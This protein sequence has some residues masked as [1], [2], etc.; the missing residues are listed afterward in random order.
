MSHHA[1]SHHDRVKGFFQT[2][3]EDEQFIIFCIDDYHNI[4]IKHRPE[5][6]TQTQSVHTST[7]LVKIF[8]NIKAVP[9]NPHQPLLPVNPVDKKLCKKLT[10][11]NMATFPK[12]MLATC[13]IGW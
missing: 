9:N 13:Q 11:K 1:A 10:D 12:H 8:P 2:A 4:Q 3:I 5:T 6:K 7:L